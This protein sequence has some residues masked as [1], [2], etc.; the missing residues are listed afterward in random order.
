MS[1]VSEPMT[2]TVHHAMQVENLFRMATAVPGNADKF[3]H[4]PSAKKQPPEPPNQF[5]GL[6]PKIMRT[7]TYLPFSIRQD[8]KT[9]AR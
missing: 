7:S 8:K 1:R 5:F 6:P 3:L 4:P 2:Q 9:K